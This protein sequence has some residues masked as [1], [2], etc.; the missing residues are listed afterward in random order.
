MPGG[1]QVYREYDLFTIV[2]YKL[3]TIP[4]ALST[5]R[6]S[7]HV[8]SA[9][10]IRLNIFMY[11]FVCIYVR[12]V[13]NKFLLIFYYTYIDIRFFYEANIVGVACMHTHLSTNKTSGVCS[14]LRRL[15]SFSYTYLLYINAHICRLHIEMN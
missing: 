14:F 13:T 12:N 11:V 7:F 5:M 2:C 6:H 8:Y 3:Y 10:Y 1:V 15:L 4:S 9:A